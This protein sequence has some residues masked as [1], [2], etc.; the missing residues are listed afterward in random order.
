MDPLFSVKQ[1]RKPTHGNNESNKSN[2]S[3]CLPEGSANRKSGVYWESLFSGDLCCK[4]WFTVPRSTSRKLVSRLTDL[5]RSAVV[6]QREDVNAHIPQDIFRGIAGHT[7]DKVCIANHKAFWPHPPTLLY[8]FGD[9][10]VYGGAQC[11]GDMVVQNSSQLHWGVN[12]AP[13]VKAESS[14]CAG[15]DFMSFCPECS[16]GL[17]CGV[18]GELLKG[19]FHQARKE[20]WARKKVRTWKKKS[21]CWG[22][23][24]CGCIRPRAL[25]LAENCLDEIS[26][27][28][29]ADQQ[30]E[31]ILYHVPF[32]LNGGRKRRE[33]ST[34]G[35]D[36]GA[37]QLGWGRTFD[38]KEVFQKYN[39]N[40]C[41]E[42]WNDL[43]WLPHHD[44][45]RPFSLQ[46]L[47]EDETFAYSFS[48][49]DATHR[50]K[51]ARNYE[52]RKPW[53]HDPDASCIRI[54]RGAS[55]ETLK[56]SSAC[57]EVDSSM[58]AL[59]HG[60]NAI[61]VREEGAPSADATVSSDVPLSASS[62][63]HFPAV[64]VASN[65]REE[66][67]S[68]DY[69][70]T[71]EFQRM[72][73]VFLRVKREDR[74]PS[75]ATDDGAGE[76][77][78]LGC[79]LEVFHMRLRTHNDVTTCL[80]AIAEV[81]KEGS[82]QRGQETNTPFSM[83]CSAQDKPSDQA[84]SQNKCSDGFVQVE[85][86]ADNR[87][88]SYFTAP[89][90]ANIRVVDQPG[91]TPEA[92]L[93]RKPLPGILFEPAPSP[94]LRGTSIRLPN[95]HR[96][97]D[98]TGSFPTGSKL[99]RRLNESKCTNKVKV[100]MASSGLA[101]LPLPAL[102]S[103]I[104]APLDEGS[105]RS[106]RCST[107][108]NLTAPSDGTV[109][110][111]E[112]SMASQQCEAELFA[113]SSSLAP[114]SERLNSELQG[115]ANCRGIIQ[116][117]CTK[118]Q[119][120]PPQPSQLP[121]EEN[122]TLPYGI[123]CI[124][125][126]L[127]PP[128]QSALNITANLYAPNQVGT[129]SPSLC[130]SVGNRHVMKRYFPACFHVSS[131]ES[132]RR[133]LYPDGNPGTW[134]L[135]HAD[136][137]HP[138]LHEQGTQRASGPLEP[139]LRATIS[140]AA[141]LDAVSF[142][143][144]LYGHP[145]QF[146][147]SATETPPD[148]YANMEESSRLHR[149]PERFPSQLPSTAEALRDPYVNMDESSPDVIWFRGQRSPG[150][151][152]E[153][154]LF[155][156]RAKAGRC[157]LRPF[158]ADTGNPPH[159]CRDL[160]HHDQTSFAR[161]RKMAGS[162][163]RMDENPD[164]SSLS[165]REEST[166]WPSSVVRVSLRGSCPAAPHSRVFEKTRWFSYARAGA[167]THGARDHCC[168]GMKGNRSQE[169]SVALPSVSTCSSSLQIGGLGT[170]G[171]TI[172]DYNR[173][174]ILNLSM[175]GPA[176][177]IVLPG[178]KAGTRQIPH[179]TD[180]QPCGQSE[181]CS[182][183]SRAAGLSDELLPEDTVNLRIE[184]SQYLR[185]RLEAVISGVWSWRS[186]SVSDFSASHHDKPFSTCVAQEAIRNGFTPYILMHYASTTCAEKALQPLD[187]SLRCRRNIPFHGFSEKLV[188]SFCSGIGHGMMY[189]SAVPGSVFPI[190][191]EQ[192]GLGAFNMI[193][194][195]LATYTEQLQPCS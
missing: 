131:R 142:S 117:A 19:I 8:L 35:A 50:Q 182:E 133:K 9:M 161:C 18:E 97:K 171:D 86:D 150:V 174:S 43:Q 107:L 173:R 160:P 176:T 92:N 155:P 138:P 164:T 57:V 94:S 163:M 180:K 31:R 159:R 183:L 103:V 122:H 66:A 177:D 186:D 79:I 67:F 70:A 143:S 75:S 83:S 189:Y 127:E 23:H 7:R 188:D 172:L 167:D 89:Q 54:V 158:T 181:D 152:A 77:L 105:R 5:L 116:E 125:Q 112:A 132:H 25:G 184:Y 15:S 99:A 81:A 88:H 62:T 195:A 87:T 32:K 72:W 144:R 165:I 60:S 170:P 22:Y 6:D 109:R 153:S 137:Q 74:A 121:G 135:H 11:M 128:E 27:T 136:I 90:S 140:N 114:P 59:K 111:N 69:V 194:G 47:L 24:G 63:N 56:R 51:T 96:S 179:S 130:S 52:G 118:S 14:N 93:C 12:L 10:K 21:L 151:Q 169:A 64:S 187:M 141:P 55:P 34:D 162:V 16:D 76:I 80:N 168:G 53:E 1:M 3:S 134:N 37:V 101:D 84:L 102:T 42:K 39:V 28:C 40:M 193:V 73:P 4:L 49:N 108:G 78:F 45:C 82:Y 110:T 26:S 36:G 191:C 157:K 104:S 113:A 148:S 33:A 139:P 61:N 106:V 98:A 30:S 46:S 85:S 91:G 115:T 124:A 119:D 68:V 29:P 48:R 41:F 17:Y 145:T 65:E 129:A 126:H 146:P 95:N 178:P 38:W 120:S 175:I 190:H 192:G 185:K 147:Q 166:T 58:P 156:K 44:T 13:G 149:H 154:G 100:C 2:H 71:A 20:Y 123:R